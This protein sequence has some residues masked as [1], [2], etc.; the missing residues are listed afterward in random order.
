MPIAND[1]AADADAETLVMGEVS[2][3]R[4]A[5]VE[6]SDEADSSFEP[7][8]GGESE[9]DEDA[10]DLEVESVEPTPPKRP[11]LPASSGTGEKGGAPCKRPLDDA[12][13][14]QC[15]VFKCFHARGATH[16]PTCAH[17]YNPAS[18]FHGMKLSI[19]PPAAN[20]KQTDFEGI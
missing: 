17:I 1:D 11:A 3:S 19:S 7:E 16:S 10:S 2:P 6:S 4:D 8:E 18:H 12:V 9:V 5:A 20:M 14:R 15:M 13:T